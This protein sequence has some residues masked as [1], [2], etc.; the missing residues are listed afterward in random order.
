MQPGSSA[1]HLTR[2]LFK[3]HFGYAPAHV[4]IAPGHVALLG[5]ETQVCDGVVIGAAID[6]FV[7]IASGPRTDGKVELVF[8][9]PSKPEV[10]WLTDLKP[11]PAVPWADPV[12]AVLAQLRKVGVHF[13]GFS[14]AVYSTIP[15]GLGLGAVSALEIATAVTIRQLFPYSLT[16]TGATLPPKR[17]DR[18]KLPALSKTERRYLAALCRMAA[19]EQ[20]NCTSSFAEHIPPLFG[21]AWHLLSIDCKVESVEPMSVIGETLI[22]C[23]TGLRSYRVTP[24]NDELLM[25]CKSVAGKLRLKSVRALEPHMLKPAKDKLNEAEFNSVYHLV[26]ELHRTVA[27]ERALLDDDHYQFGQYMFYSYESARDLF[28]MHCGEIDLLMELARSHPGCLGARPIDGGATIN[29]VAYHQAESFMHHITRSYESRT[30]KKISPA[31]YQI[32]DGVN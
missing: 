20:M 21:K 3:K 5:T 18:G 11:N 10:F 32:V 9:A 22:V 6:R 16:E 4:V 29:L 26:C 13:S 8:S 23:D 28:N 2:E 30:G 31:V 14:A 1:Q 12:K 17:D 7:G 15:S 19:A 27:A 25:H 24:N